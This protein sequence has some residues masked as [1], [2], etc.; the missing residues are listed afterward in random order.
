MAMK[1]QPSATAKAPSTPAEQCI[2]TILHAEIMRDLDTGQPTLL[3]ST[4]ANLGD[5]AEVTPA[6]LLAKVNQ[7]RADADR[8]EQLAAEYAATVVLPAFIEHYAI[9]LIETS[10]SKLVENAPELAAGFRA[11]SALKNDGTFI[12]VVPEGQPPIERLAAI[13]DLVLDQRERSAA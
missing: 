5:L 13:R 9:D 4:E 2:T 8:I 10:T 12:V 11:F 1:A 3:A 7:L 6:Q